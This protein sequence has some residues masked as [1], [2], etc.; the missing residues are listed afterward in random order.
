MNKI[1]RNKKGSILVFAL[2]VLS[3]ILLATFSLSSIA[4]IERES[5]DI[6]VNSSTAFQ[7]ADKGMEDFLQQIYKDLDQNDTLNDMADA[8]GSYYKCCGK[9]GQSCNTN[10]GPARIGDQ[11]TQFIITAYKDEG[12]TVTETVNSQSKET[13]GWRHVIPIKDCDTKLAD[14]ARFRSTGNHNNAARAVFLRLRDSLSRG[15]VAHWSFE[16]RAQ[17]ARLEN[18]HEDRIS[19]IA[20]DFSKQNHFLT[21]CKMRDDDGDIPVDTDG[22]GHDDAKIKEFTNCFHDETNG[23]SPK[24]GYTDS[25]MGHSD[26]DDEHDTSGSWVKGIVK[27]QDNMGNGALGDGSNSE[28]LKFNGSTYLAT[29]YDS[30][31][32]SDV[33]NCIN[34][35][36]DKLNVDDG[37]AISMWVKENTANGAGYLI[38]KYDNNKGYEVYIDSSGKICFQLN[39]KNVCSSSS[40][41]DDTNWHHVVVN[42]RKVDQNMNIF[43]DGVQINVN[44]N[45][46]FANSIGD[47]EGVIVVIG[48]QYNSGISNYFT[49]D[50]DDVRIWNRAL[51]EEEIMKLCV[52]SVKDTD[53]NGACDI[54]NN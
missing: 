34:N 16:D 23:M 8:L 3:F 25:S 6:S 47:T 1:T 20:Q 7:Q 49:G 11:N 17:N 50:I 53:D 24:R 14:V 29:Y 21:L 37:I 4:R 35:T 12:D 39:N 30:S 44:S 41:F 33:I 52:N 13:G 9:N 45:N 48:A 40:E 54:P 26:S 38:S 36:D 5:A 18:N 43:V 32:D 51:T 42:W 27:E 31:C 15:L 46:S 2:I 22:D 19:F 10:G 28:A